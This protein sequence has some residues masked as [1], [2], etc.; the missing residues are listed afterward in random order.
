[1]AIAFHEEFAGFV[2]SGL[3]M[4]NNLIDV[5]GD[6]TYQAAS[7]NVATF[8]AANTAQAALASIHET[9]KPCFTISNR[10]VVNLNAIGAYTDAMIAASN[11][12]ST[13]RSQFTTQDPT[14]PADYHGARSRP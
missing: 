6:G 10:F 8:Q 9:D 11:S 4:S 14:L 12:T 13:W 2:T 1:M 3:G 5:T 7:T